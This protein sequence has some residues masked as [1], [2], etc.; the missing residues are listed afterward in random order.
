MILENRGRRAQ[1]PPIPPRRQKQKTMPPPPPPPKRA[2]SRIY[3][4]EDVHSAPTMIIE[5]NQMRRRQHG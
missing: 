5:I 4:E 3:V 1:P 2:A